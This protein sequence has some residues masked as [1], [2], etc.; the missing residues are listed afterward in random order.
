MLLHHVQPLAAVLHILVHF[1]LL[2]VAVLHLLLYLVQLLVAVLYVLIYL[3]LPHGFTDILD[4][5]IAN[6]F[7]PSI[8]EHKILRDLI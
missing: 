2:L 6:A 4:F 8:P 7:C 5:R 3:V 1:V